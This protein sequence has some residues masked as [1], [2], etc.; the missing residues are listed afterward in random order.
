LQKV[1]VS[2]AS[3]DPAARNQPQ[4]FSAF[5]AL[6]NGHD[7]GK[8][9]L[10]VFRLD[11]GH[12]IY[13]QTYPIFFPDPLAVVN[14]NIRIRRIQF[15]AAGWYDFVLRVNGEHLTQRRIRV[16]RSPTDNPK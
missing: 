8:L 5:A 15:P 12:Q 16:Y 10:V 3:F 14:V 1:R 9:E 2:A 13:S 7:Q 6:T 11:N 4:R